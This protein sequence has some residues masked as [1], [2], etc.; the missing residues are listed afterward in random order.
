MERAEAMTRY[1]EA[2]LAPLV[3]ELA[4]T[5]NALLAQ[6][7]RI[8]E[9]ARENGALAERLAAQKRLREAAMARAAELE[10]RLEAA[11]RTPDPEPAPDPFP[12]PIPPAPNV[13]AQ[14][15]LMRRVLLAVV[16]VTTLAIAVVLAPGWR[17]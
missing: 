6:A 5:R 12:A 8:A 2:L 16:V 7:D 1:N 10:Q 4:V 14:A 17:W 3:A 15:A 9:L 11:T 13:V